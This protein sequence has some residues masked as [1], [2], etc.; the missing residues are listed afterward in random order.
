MPEPLVMPNI[1]ESVTQGIVLRWLKAEG[2]R[3]ERDEEIVEV[4][5][6]KV[7]VE[8]PSPWAGTLTQIVAREGD[9]VPVGEALAFIETAEGG[10]GM[11]AQHAAPAAATS[12]APPAPA[13]AT[14][15]PRP[16]EHAGQLRE[17][18]PAPS[19]NGGG[20]FSPAVLSLA[21]EHNVDLSQLS[22]SGMEGRITR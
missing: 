22:G 5:T 17:A 7:N 14:S 9:E 18:A 11:V 10:Q 6:E 2:D 12:D 13:T 16:A 3:V 20:R 4:E 1:G 21:R 8:I 15:P 19:A